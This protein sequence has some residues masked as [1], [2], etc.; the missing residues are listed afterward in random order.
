MRAQRSSGGRSSGSKGQTE[1]RRHSSGRSGAR[2]QAAGGIRGKIQGLRDKKEQRSEGRLDSLRERLQTRLH[3]QDKSGGLG[4]REVAA[5]T[6]T[7]NRGGI[8]AKMAERGGTPPRQI[9][10]AAVKEAR[11]HIKG[12]RADMVRPS[13][14]EQYKK[15][16]ERMHRTGKSP[17]EAAG[18]TKAFYAYRAAVVHAAKAELRESL[19]ARDRASREK[20]DD[21]R[22]DAEKRISVALAMLDRYP[23]GGR[24][25]ADNFQ[26]TSL[27]TGA[28]QSERS[29]GKRETLAERAPDWRERVF[30]NVRERDKD[31]VSVAALT[32][33]RPAEIA[34]GVQVDKIAGGGLRFTIHGAKLDDATGR[35][36]KSRTIE[37]TRAD[38]AKSA[39]G[40]HLLAAGPA[41]RE[42]PLDGTPSAF[43]HRVQRAGERAG[44]ERVSP[45]DYRHSFADRARSDGAGRDELAAAMGHRSETSQAAYGGRAGTGGGGFSRASASRP[46]RA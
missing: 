11:V 34:K 17:D 20:N 9:D 41:A 43:A 13:T 1:D 26:R 10:N 31:A 38:A 45:Y 3:S 8:L 29:N 18:T 7:A 42:V 27:Y 15:M 19:T 35:G 40:R 44:V 12:W 24:D 30:Q 4:G 22:R 37:V 23:P 28:H 21:A 2:E 33:A 36:Q 5:V 16:T 25:K 46:T 14:Q 39:E 6:V 32:G